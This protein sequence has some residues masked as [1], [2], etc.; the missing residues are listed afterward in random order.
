MLRAFADLAIEHFWI[1]PYDQGGCRCPA[2]K[3]WGGNGFL[4]NAEAVAGLVRRHMPRAKTVISTWEFGYFEGDPEWDAF[5]AAMARHPAWADMVMAEHHAD[6]PLYVREHGAPG[7]LPLLNFPEI[8]MFEMGPWGGFGANP[9]PAR[10]QRIWD[11]CG[12]LLSGGYPYSEG[13]FED[14]NKAISLQFYW[15]PRRPALDTVR[16]YAAGEFGPDVAGDVTKAVQ[17]MEEDHGHHAQEDAGDGVI[18]KLAK[19]AQAG[20]CAALMRGLDV[21]VEAPARRAW[22]W[23]ILAIRAALDDELARSGGRATPASQALF[24]EVTDIYHAAHAEPY[25]APPLAR[26]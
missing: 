5:Y 4:R 20:A 18:Y 11:Q 3:P 12:H 8:S 7:G 21:R 2:C 23:R 16:E 13:I 17:M 15:D 25:L 10:F 22:R 24:R 19:T 1:W 26:V 14:I 9:A 6:Y